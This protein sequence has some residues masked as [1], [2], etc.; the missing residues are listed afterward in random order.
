[1]SV[2]FHL[3][4][5]RADNEVERTGTAGAVRSALLCSALLCSALLDSEY[6]SQKRRQQAKD[7]YGMAM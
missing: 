3:R 6:P 7:K 5:Y 1:M 4:H 2:S